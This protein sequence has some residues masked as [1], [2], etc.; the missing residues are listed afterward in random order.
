MNLTDV[1]RFWRKYGLVVGG[2][3]FVVILAVGAGIVW[4]L[5]ERQ[6]RKETVAPTAPVSKP[7][8]DSDLCTYELEVPNAV[9]GL[10][11]EPGKPSQYRCEGLPGTDKYIFETKGPGSS[12]YTKVAEGADS[13]S[14]VV[15]CG[16]QL[17]CIVCAG[18]ICTT[19]AQSDSKAVNSAACLSTPTPAAT[20][21]ISICKT[22]VDQNNQIVNG[23]TI[24]AS[25]L[26]LNGL[27][28][29]PVTSEGAPNGTLPLTSWTTPL[30]YN[31]DL[32]SNFAGND[33]ACVTHT[34]LALDGNGYYYG[35]ESLPSSGWGT[36]KYHDQFIAK[37]T[38]LSDLLAYNGQLFDTNSGNDSNRNLNSDGHIKLTA[39]KPNRTLLVLNQYLGVA[40]SP[41]PSPSISPTPTPSAAASPT[42][43]ASATPAGRNARCNAACSTT[44]DCLVG[45]SCVSGACRN[46]ACSSEEDCAC[47]TAEAPVAQAPVVKTTPSPIATPSSLPQSGSTGVLF[48]SLGIGAA[49]LLMGL[50]LGL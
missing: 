49:L 36:A 20:G 29:N 37:S 46:P 16:T 24:S 6:R 34:G 45:Y 33:A 42:P 48:G 40:T 3:L 38:K 35:Q 31:T 30:T 43:V 26:S 13:L 4:N 27:V 39:D 25:S 17:R 8:A 19:V 18:E 47:S 22:I 12:T 50:F 41:S 28:P 23:T 21:T 15:P 44:N 7:K 32:F 11:E 5:Q 14:P 1:K 2:V 10:T 9:V